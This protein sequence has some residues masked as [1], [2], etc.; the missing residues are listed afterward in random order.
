M[1]YHTF[2]VSKLQKDLF[3]NNYLVCSKLV[4]FSLFD[5]LIYKTKANSKGTFPFILQ[6]DLESLVQFNFLKTSLIFL[7]SHEFI[8]KTILSER[9]QEK[10]MK[11]TFWDLKIHA[12]VFAVLVHFKAFNA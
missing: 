11:S 2:N 10:K 8:T 7:S 12:Y 3:T 9:T 6:K 5:L 4:P 1:Y